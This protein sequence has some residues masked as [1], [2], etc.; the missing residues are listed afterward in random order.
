MKRF[1]TVLSLLLIL[2][3]AGCADNSNINSSNMASYMKVVEYMEANLGNKTNTYIFDVN[4]LYIANFG[5]FVKQKDVNE[6]FMSKLKQRI[7]DPYYYVAN[8]FLGLVDDTLNDSKYIRECAEYLRNTI[9]PDSIY[10][11]IINLGIYGNNIQGANVFSLSYFGKGINQI[12]DKQIDFVVEALG[13]PNISVNDF[14]GI[15]E[16]SGLKGY[17]VSAVK[18]LVSSELT[19]KMSG[20]N[21]S[22]VNVKLGI[23]VNLQYE[24]QNYMDRC[25]S[26]F[27]ETNTDGSNFTDCSIIVHDNRLGLLSAYVPSRSNSSNIFRMN[28]GNFVENYYELT[29]KIMNE[30]MLGI[31]LLNV[32]DTRD[33]IK[34]DILSLKDLFCS[35]RL[36]NN[37][38]SGNLH[39]SLEISDIL[40]SGNINYR[41]PSVVFEIKEN[42]NQKYYYK[43]N[44]MNSVYIGE[45]LLCE[46]FSDKEK[47]NTEYGCSLVTPTGIIS[48]A[49][50]DYYTAV[51]LIGTSS[52]SRKLDS[53]FLEQLCE[54]NEGLYNL[55]DKHYGESTK[56]LWSVQDIDEIQDNVYTVNYNILSDY[57]NSKL[58]ELDS[59]KINS[60]ENRQL[61][62][63]RFEQFYS[64]IDYYK[65]SLGKENFDIINNNINKIRVTKREDLLKYSA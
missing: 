26:G 56:S 32:S 25:L 62:E 18:S 47:N 6:R 33:D 2:L 27:M 28:T 7:N 4:D 61:F 41:T 16:V 55:L 50:N 13:N 64:V 52:N 42:A 54:V 35:Q 59:I 60:V 49:V 3:C 1:N 63:D 40:F 29:S 12:T 43:Q 36:S 23:D 31:S 21:L 24:V 9:L 34:S 11:Y 39:S 10:D 44:S 38:G 19:S 65:D 20:I 30:K 37:K 22:G 51:A 53:E 57:I 48:F 15:G 14:E 58:I 46:F 45:P 17:E 8:E 5:S